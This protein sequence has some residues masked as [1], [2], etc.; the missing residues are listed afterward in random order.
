MLRNAMKQRDLNLLAM[1]IDLIVP[2]LALLAVVIFVGVI[3]GSAFA[4]MNQ[5]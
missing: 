5:R 1:A 4:N 2:P 3:Q